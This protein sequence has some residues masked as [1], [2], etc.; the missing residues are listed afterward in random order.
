MVTN[1]N[2]EVV[3]SENDDT[4][5]E[6]T[7]E[8][9]VEETE[10]KTDTEKPKETLE[11]KRAR[12]QRQLKQIDKKLGTAETEEPSHKTKTDD[13]GY[14]EL[15]YLTAKGIE[16]DDEIDLVKTVM[17]DTGKSLKDVVSSKYFQ[18]E[19]KEMRDEKTAKAAVPS[20]SKRSSSPARDSVEYWLNKGEL[21][22]ASDT[23]LRRKVVN[24]RIERERSSHFT[25][26]PV[27]GK[28]F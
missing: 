22:P 20:S 23:E 16:S 8:E 21:P 12:L 19:L 26:N 15:A 10:G 6:D 25:D 28:R 27:A 11:Q 24:A 14:G 1:E 4:A 9:A 5:T 2:E 3:T 13:I 17:K 7:T 18:A